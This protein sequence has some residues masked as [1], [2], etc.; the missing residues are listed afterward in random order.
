MLLRLILNEFRYNKFLQNYDFSIENDRIT[1]I[2]NMET[3]N[4]FRLILIF[5]S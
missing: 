3:L 5:L 4:F 2:L 1:I